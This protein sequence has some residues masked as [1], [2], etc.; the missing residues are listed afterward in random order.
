[1]FIRFKCEKC[2]NGI[3]APEKFAGRAAKCP[4]CK[5]V[6]IVPALQ[7]GYEP[8]WINDDFKDCSTNKNKTQIQTKY[9]LQKRTR[10][11]PFCKETI[12]VIATMCKTC[13]SALG[14]DITEVKKQKE[15]TSIELHQQYELLEC[16]REGE[17][18][19]ALLFGISGLALYVSGWWIMTA[20]PFLWTFFIWITGF[21]FLIYGCM[22]YAIFKGRSVVWGVIFGLTFWP[23]MIFLHDVNKDKLDEIVIQLEFMDRDLN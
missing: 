15:R 5:Q 10:M 9:K 17:L 20:V 1:M 22:S 2:G 3:K 21:L 7:K 6:I 8:S 11:C 4:K 19:S 16:K 18:K 23:L 14:H 12:P 13:K